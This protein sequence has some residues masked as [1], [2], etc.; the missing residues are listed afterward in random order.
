MSIS[1][2]RASEYFID[3]FTGRSEQTK[4]AYHLDLLQFKLY[5]VRFRKH[6][7]VKGDPETL[8]NLEAEL[9]KLK[10]NSSTLA[11]LCVITAS[12]C[13]LGPCSMP[14]ISISPAF[15]RGHR[16]LLWLPRVG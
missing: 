3:S 4:Q 11:P 6:L 15:Q 9:A 12:R 13:A 8:A 7:L 16:R 14:A 10:A 2:N 5:L 1:F